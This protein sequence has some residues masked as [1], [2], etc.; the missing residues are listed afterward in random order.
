MPLALAIAPALALCLLVAI[1]YFPAIGGGLV[2]D[3][4]AFTTALPVQEWAGIWQIWFQPSSLESEGHYWPLLYTTFWLEH[5]LWGFAAT[6]YHI[7]NLLLHTAVTLLLWRLLLRLG[8]TGAWFVAAVFAVH[9]LH[10]ESVAWIIGR[11]D[12][13]AALFSLAC[14][15]SYLRFIE[16]RQPGRYILTLVY[17]VLGL[18]CK[19]IVV[20]LPVSLLLWHWWKHGRITVADC[21]RVL[22]LLLLGL[23]ITLADLSYYTGREVLSLDYSLLD[24]VLIAAR[25]LCFYAGQL[26]WPTDLA[27]IYPLWE[28]STGD[29]LAWV[30]VIGVVAVLALLWFFRHRIGRGPLAG[31]LFFVVTLSPTL[32]FLDYGY[33]QFSLVA[34]RY[35][36]LAGVGVTA[37]LLGAAAQAVRGLSATPRMGVRALAVLVLVVLGTVT[38]KQSGIYR[39]NTTFYNH[40]ISLNP[41]ARHAHYNLG[42]EYYVQKRYEEAIKAHQIAGEQDPE[43]IWI[44]ISLGKISEDVGRFDEAE[45]HYRDALRIDRKSRAAINHLGALQLKQ[46]RYPEALELFQ[47]LIELDPQ[48]APIYSGRGVALS[49]LNRL[50]EALRSFDRALELDPSLDEARAN[51]QHVLQAMQ[52]K[53]K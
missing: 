30:F 1:S 38:W 4:A 46:Q 33:M 42:R 2:W 39:D 36:Y 16:H 22:P 15:L 18:L 34:D 28:I 13:L 29:Y 7:V 53:E 3:D 48:Y 49:G 40:I 43:Y 14:A 37:A 41:Q 25:S 21:V 26:V 12:M 20:T 17:F 45:T 47:T 23:T 52:N 44:P 8:V 24:R 31:V 51:R 50:E 10:V 35:Q 11:K 27:V 32:G 9:P 5:K 19:S 6:G